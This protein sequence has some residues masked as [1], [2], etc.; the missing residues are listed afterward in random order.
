MKLEKI[1]SIYFIGIGGI[2]MSGLA[3]YFHLNGRRISGYD[4]SPSALTDEL[5]KEGMQIHF[6]ED[7]NAIPKE[8][9]L[10]VFTPAVPPDHKELVY[11]REHNY[12]VIKRSDLLEELTKDSF[13]IAVAGTHG[14]TT[15]TSMIAHIL[16]YSGYDCTAFLGGIAANYETNFLAG[17]NNTVVVEADEFDR[18]FLKLHPNIAVITSCDPD[19]LDVYGTKEEVEKAYGEFAGKIKKGGVL[20]TKKQLPFL[21]Y[22]AGLTPLYYSI[23]GEVDFKAENV[24]LVDG[25]YAFDFKTSTG[26]IS[27]IHLGV[28]GYYNVENAIAASAV[29]W[30]LNIEK[31][32]IREALNTFR[33]V[34]RRFEFIVRNDH[35]VYIDDYAHHPEEL[36][37]FL[38]SVREIF[39]GKNI[40]CIFQPHLYTRTRDFADDFGK[41]LS[42]ADE[43]ILLPIY[44]ARELPIAGV[45]SEMLLDKVSVLNKMVCK[46]KDL[47]N[48]LKK[49][50]LEV[51][52][53][54]GAGD[55]DQLVEPIKQM[56]GTR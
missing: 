46:K 5:V 55:I 50:K 30:Q 27:D 40:T 11:Y 53:T 14:K 38:K 17:K 2:G 49:R 1:H 9:D 36:K 13:T 43:L 28:A 42:L 6:E 37:A 47:I 15:T 56:L 21:Q 35:A 51:V 3:R 7:V 4:K 29:A 24:R 16:K 41:A 48:E 39:P 18:S 25:T 34:K 26:N 22:V 45:S 12:P 33:G 23:S 19:H 8:I 10:V 44:P 32:M 20:I 52:V 54:V 31:E